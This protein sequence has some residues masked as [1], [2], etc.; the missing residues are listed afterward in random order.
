MHTSIT[1]DPLKCVFGPDINMLYR[2]FF[3]VLKRKSKIKSSV[4]WSIF[5][6]VIPCMLQPG[7]LMFNNTQFI[8]KCILHFKV[9]YK[10]SLIF[11]KAI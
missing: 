9:Q 1:P 2:L 8:I 6:A 11:I 10:N 7:Q 5:A 4:M 3:L